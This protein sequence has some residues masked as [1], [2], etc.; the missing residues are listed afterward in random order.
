ITNDVTDATSG[1]NQLRYQLEGSYSAWY[2]FSAT[3]TLTIWDMQSN[4]LSA[5]FTD[6]AGNISEVS[7]TITHDDPYEG[8]NGNN[9]F[10]DA[11]S[12]YTF[13][14]GYVDGDLNSTFG[15]YAML[16][17]NLDFYRI[18]ID[19]QTGSEVVI[20]HIAGTSEITVELYT[21]DGTWLDEDTAL[22]SSE[23]FFTLTDCES[24][25][26]VYFYLR[27]FRNDTTSQPPMYNITWTN[28][29]SEACN[30]G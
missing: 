4:T 14:T 19:E 7:T 28:L 23:A 8:C 1:I 15:D 5:E 13:S 22:P 2:S 10:A 26:G 12:L 24:N 18:A 6:F 17:D 27:I 21:Y 20:D 3:R 9:S 30:G 11:F 29:F 25:G 16:S